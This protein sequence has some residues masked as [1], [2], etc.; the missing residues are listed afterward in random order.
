MNL[1]DIRV[2]RING[3]TIMEVYRTICRMRKFIV[4]NENYNAYDLDIASKCCHS[5]DYNR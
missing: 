3:G 5:I 2:S 4:P 1:K